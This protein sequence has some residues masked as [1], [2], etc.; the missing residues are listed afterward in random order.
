MNRGNQAEQHRPQQPEI[1]AGLA[2]TFEAPAPASKSMN[3]RAHE[4][5]YENLSK[6]TVTCSHTQVRPQDSFDFDVIFYLYP[7]KTNAFLEFHITPL[8]IHINTT[9]IALIQAPTFQ[10]QYNLR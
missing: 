3:E 1:T 6:Y 9:E 10:L 2:K 4:K 5:E 7:A 8:H